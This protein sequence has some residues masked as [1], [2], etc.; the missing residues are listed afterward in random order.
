MKIE[1][2]FNIKQKVIVI[3]NDEVKRGTILNIEIKAFAQNRINIKYEVEM[4]RDTTY[5][6]D[7][8]NQEE[9]Y[10]SIDDFTDKLKK[11]L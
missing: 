11:Q 2:K 10:A 5:C 9:V 7:V 4:G 6:R 1:A 3:H 8:F